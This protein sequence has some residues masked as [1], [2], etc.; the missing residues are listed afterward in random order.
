MEQILGPIPF[1]VLSKILDEEL[2]MVIEGQVDLCASCNTAIQ[3]WDE[4]QKET[5]D[6][7]ERLRDDFR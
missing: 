5:H 2:G 7:E 4:L 3:R 1:Q 6:I